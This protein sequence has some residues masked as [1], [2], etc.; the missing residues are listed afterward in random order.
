[1]S[2]EHPQLRVRVPPELKEQLEDIARSSGRTL[3]AEIVYRLQRSIDEEKEEH[4]D[5]FHTIEMKV[6]DHGRNTPQIGEALR[7]IE[8]EIRA[9]RTAIKIETNI[10]EE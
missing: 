6:L 3:T 4:V 2:R 8:E 1:M 5:G 7:K 10:M 9:V